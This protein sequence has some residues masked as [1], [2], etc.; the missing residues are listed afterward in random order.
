MNHLRRRPRLIPQL[1]RVVQR[2]RHARPN[3]RRHRVRNLPPARVRRVPRLLKR[4]PAEQLHRQVVAPGVVPEPVDRDDV[5]VREA[6]GDPRL[7]QEHRDEP[8]LAAKLGADHLQRHEAI[9]LGPQARGVNVGHAPAPD[10][11]EDVVLAER[12]ELDDGRG[13]SHDGPS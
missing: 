10:R 7:V 5:R 1:V 3:P 9:G 2:L 8:G 12:L 11:G 4:A 13:G 6:G